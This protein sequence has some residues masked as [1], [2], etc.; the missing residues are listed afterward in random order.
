MKKMIIFILSIGLF[1][2]SC[3]DSDVTPECVLGTVI[4]YEYCSNAVLIQVSSNSI[5]GGKITYYDDTEF[6]NIIRAPAEL[7]EYALGTI[8][9]TYRPY[10]KEKDAGLFKPRDTP[11]NMYNWPFDIPTIVITDDSTSNCPNHDD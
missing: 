10:D 11:C 1:A 7:G 8:Y 6:E 4:G 9:F 5:I 3:E 2:F